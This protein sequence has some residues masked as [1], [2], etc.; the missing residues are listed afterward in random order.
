MY[1]AGAMTLVANG[2]VDE[3]SLRGNADQLHPSVLDRQG[4]D[5][6]LGQP[7]HGKA[8]CCRQR[9]PAPPGRAW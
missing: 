4:A 8:Q 7:T 6:V 1:G 5:V 3:V 9:L 2:F